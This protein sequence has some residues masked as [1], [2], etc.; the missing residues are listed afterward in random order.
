MRPLSARP[1]T[2]GGVALSARGLS[3]GEVA[4]RV[5]AGHVNQV[6]RPTS[7][8]LRS[9]IGSNLFTRFNA[10]LGGL[11]VATL[12]VGSPGD[13]LFG[14]EVVANTL[15][16]VVEEIRAKLTLDRMALV[17]A[18]RAKTRRDGRLVE[19]PLDQL[20][21][22]DVV[23]LGRGD[24]V[25]VDGVVLE[26]HGLEVDE[27]ILTGEFRPLPQ[28]PGDAVYSGSIVSGGSGVFRADAVGSST[29]AA[30][31]EVEARKFHPATSELGWESTAFL[32]WSP[33]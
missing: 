3:A 29:Y 2:A 31:I 26:S 10:L 30:R 9:I 24:Q 13:G 15:V 5:Q 4:E 33:L 8:S 11:L 25:P 27:S 14:L 12:M 23:Q 21:L 1:A 28:K 7:R 19:L 20:V 22:D 17:T 18:P 6:E 16:G 32:C